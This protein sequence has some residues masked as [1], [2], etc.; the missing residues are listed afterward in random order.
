MLCQLASSSELYLI[1]RC[2]SDN[3]ERMISEAV[4]KSD[5]CSA[6]LDSN[7]CCGEQH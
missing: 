4:D 3:D 6:G 7:V 2:D 1:T 5:L